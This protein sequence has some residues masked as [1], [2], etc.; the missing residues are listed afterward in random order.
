MAEIL[1]DSNVVIAFMEDENSNHKSASLLLIDNENEFSISSLSMTE[2]LIA[3]YRK[4]YE[5]ALSSILRIQDLVVGILDLT[6][7][8]AILAAKLGAEKNLLLADL[9]ILAT[10][11]Y[12]QL[13]LWTFDRRLANKSRRITYLL[14]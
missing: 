3:A 4:G 6:S 7:P 1:L 12:H 11:R 10:A 8:I 9:V 14:A 13:Q 5:Y 2:C